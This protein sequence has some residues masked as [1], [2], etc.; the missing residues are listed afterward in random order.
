MTVR[1]IVCFAVL[2]SLSVADQVIREATIS[3]FPR[4]PDP[5]QH[6]LRKRGCTVPQPPSS[7]KLENVIRG[8]FRNSQDTDWAV[9]CDIRL[10]NRS[11]ILV[12]WSGS[13][14]KPDIVADSSVINHDCWSLITA[15]DKSYIM[16]HYRAYG[17]PKP[18]PID[19]HGIDIGICEKASTVSY[20]YRN[21]WLTLT[22]AD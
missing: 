12:Y 7:R 4:L 18:P 16:E 11:M 22:G 6:D 13:V 1:L 19:H 20:F 21:R 2:G 9:L 3:Q 10:K 17:G 14:L 5:I 15:V 8:H